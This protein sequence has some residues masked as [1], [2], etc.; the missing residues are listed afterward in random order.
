MLGTAKAERTKTDS[1]RKDGL[2]RKR[3]KKRSDRIC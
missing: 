2:L 3:R 1:E